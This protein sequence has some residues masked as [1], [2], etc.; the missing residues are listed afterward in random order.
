MT[1]EGCAFN[2]RRIRQL[3][4]GEFLIDMQKFVEERLK[5]VVLPKGRAS[6]KAEQATEDEVEGARATCG[7]LNWLAKEGRPDLAGASSMASSRLNHLTV[8]DIVAL[9]D[10][11]KRAKERSSL[12]IRI[13][14]LRRMKL[15]V[16]SDA[17]WGNAGFHSQGGHV[18]LAHEEELHE[19]GEARANV[20]AWRS[21][22]LQRVVNSTL[23][24]ET[25]A[26]SRG[27]GDLLWLM[28]VLEDFTDG[29]FD[30][31]DWP[32]RLSAAK[33]LAMASVESSES[34]KGALAIVD[35]KSLYDQLA[36]ETTGGQDRRTAIEVQ[37]IR[38]DLNA[39]SG[40]VRWVDH[41]SM[42]MG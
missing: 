37:I 31:R 1:P 3:D 8:E 18:L 25:Q 5:P 20:L 22:K 12:T 24:A 30:L 36:K 6:Q 41:L 19:Q 35:A 13:Q 26:L 2:G 29:R 14:P 27:L 10:V 23:A 28:V 16:V 40:H 7:A 38:E 21:G 33:V 39:L 15:A 11:V 42:R 32:Q 17:S 4:S 9:N 34:L